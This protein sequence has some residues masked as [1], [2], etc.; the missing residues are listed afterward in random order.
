MDRTTHLVNISHKSHYGYYWDG[1]K[2]L[3]T[4]FSC[5]ANTCEMFCLTYAPYNGVVKPT[6]KQA[7]FRGSMPSSWKPGMTCMPCTVEIVK[8]TDAPGTAGN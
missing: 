6:A 1:E 7:V 8:Y 3:E 2:W 5:P 4:R